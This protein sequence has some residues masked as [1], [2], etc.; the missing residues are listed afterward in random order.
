MPAAVSKLKSPTLEL[1]K[2]D[3]IRAMRNMQ[4]PAFDVIWADPP[5]HLSGGG[6]TNR[7]GKRVSVNKGDWDKLLEPD[8]QVWRARRW[9]DMARR[10]LKPHGTVWICASMHSVGRSAYALEVSGF[11]ILNMIQVVKSNPPPNLGCRCFTHAHE[12]IIWASLGPK[13]K[14]H[15]DYQWV[16]GDNGGKQRRDVWQFNRAPKHERGFGSHPTQKPVA[17]VER[18]LMA[19]CP[20]GGLVLD[21]FM[22]SGTTGVAAIRCDRSFGFIGIEREKQWYDVARKRIADERQQ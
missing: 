6:G 22:G 15:F 13:V 18:C 17:L 1:I 12:T 21:P 19:S 3:A 2:G 11:R 4:A 7:G 14:H 16:K 10:M 20:D 5:Y 9:L 8:E